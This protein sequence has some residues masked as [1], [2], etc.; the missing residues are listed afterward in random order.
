MSKPVL[1]I[2]MLV[3]YIAGALT[4]L[5]THSGPSASATFSAPKILQSTESQLVGMWLGNWKGWDTHLSLD[6]NGTGLTTRSSFAGNYSDNL[7][8]SINGN[9]FNLTFEGPRKD[10]NMSG[11][12]KFDGNNLSIKHGNEDWTIYSRQQ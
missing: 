1:V 4:V 6:A 8:W 9:T 3:A 10:W 7:R 11:E 5:W 2:A 12:F